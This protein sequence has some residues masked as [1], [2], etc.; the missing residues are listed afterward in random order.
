MKN[1]SEVSRLVPQ[2]LAYIQTQFSHN[3]RCIR[4][5]NGAEFKLDSFF[6]NNG[7]THQLSCVETSQNAVVERKHQHLLVVARSL[8][9]QASLPLKFWEEAILT[10]T[11]LINRIPTPV[12]NN[13]SP[14]EPLFN[15]IPYYNNLWVF[16]CLYFAS[17]LTAYRTKFDPSAVSAFSCTPPMWKVTNSM[18]LIHIYFLSLGMLCFTSKFFLLNLSL[19]VFQGH[20]YLLIYHFQVLHKVSKTST[21]IQLKLHH[22]KPVLIS[23]QMNTPTQMPF[24]QQTRNT[25]INIHLLDEVP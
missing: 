18:I 20:L 15:K 25:L 13:K 7:I 2:F 12:L 21:M 3:I 4:T 10:T 1:K 8:M 17:T 11:Y 23:F 16:G 5:D 9:F 14:Y 19:L 22:H 24:H 6:A